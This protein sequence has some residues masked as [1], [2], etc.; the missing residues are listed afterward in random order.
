MSLEQQNEPFNIRDLTLD[1]RLQA[2]VE[3]TPRDFTGKKIFSVEFF[4]QNIGF[5]ITDVQ[6]EVNTSLQPIITITFKD[7]YGNT[8]FGKTK[9]ASA[10]LNDTVD[11]ETDFSVLFNWPPPKFLFTFKGFLGRSATW[12]INMKKSSV[13]YDS[14][15]GSYDIK[16]EFVPNQWGFL[17]DLPFLYLLAVKSLKKKSGMSEEEFKKVQTIFDLIKIGKQVEVKTQETTKEFDNIMKQMTLLK[18]QRF[19]D[20]VF[21]SKVVNYDE[22][23]T[24]QVGNQTIAPFNAV[25]VFEPKG[26]GNTSIDSQEKMKALAINSEN[27][28]RINTFLLFSSKIGTLEPEP[29]LTFEKI[30]TGNISDVITDFEQK[31][32]ARLKLLTDNITTIE[33]AIKKKTYDSSKSQ[34]EKI[35][36][37]EIFEQLAKD[38]GYIMGRILEI[39]YRGYQANRGSRDASKGQLIGRNFPLWLNDKQEEKPATRDVTGTDF[40]VEE[41][42]LQFVNDFIDAIAEG[43]A[44]ELAEDNLAAENAG[45]NL[46][47]KRISNIEALRPNPYKPFYQSIAENIM[48]RSGIAGFLTRSPDPNRPGDYDTTANRDRATAAEDIFPLADADFENISDSIITALSD[49]DFKA[50]KKFCVF[51]DNLLTEDCESLREPDGTG[52]LIEGNIISGN[53]T[54]APGSP[55]P[56]SL[57]DYRVVIER[58]ANWDG[59]FEAA[60]VQD[61]TLKE[62]MATV[63]RP[64][65]GNSLDSTNSGLIDLNALQAIKVINN[66][67]AYFKTPAAVGEDVYTYIMFDG[68]YA[69]QTQEVM[70][71]DS[72]GEA[73]NNIEEQ[74][75]S[76]EPVGFVN[77]KN[78]TDDEGNLVEV[79]QEMNNRI[80]D[81]LLL[82]Y[83]RLLNPN[84]SFFLYPNSLSPFQD[85]N[86]MDYFKVTKKLGDPDNLQVGEIPAKNLAFSIAYHSSDSAA[87]LV[88]GPFIDDDDAIVQRG[89]IKRI[90]S[91]LI[92]KLDGIEQKRNQ[93]ISDV[94]GKSGEQRDLLYKQMHVLYQQWEVLIIKDSDSAN[95]QNSVASDLGAAV[96]NPALGATPGAISQELTERY[97]KHINFNLAQSVAD[98]AYDNTFLYA[99]P[100]NSTPGFQQINV[101]N[102]LINIEPLYKPNG[103][104]TVLNIIQQICT[105]N[106]FIFIPMPGEP[107]VFST[108]EIFS[109]HP[110][111]K[112]KVKNFFYVQF[113]PTMESRA[114]LRNDDASPISSSQNVK[115]HLP[116]GTLLIKFGSPENQIV[117][118]IS[119][120]TQE[121]KSTA[122]SIVNLQ[123]LVDNENQNKKVTT[124]CSMLPVMEGRSYK[125]TAEM[126]GN[127]Q[128][129]PMQFF[130][131]DSIPL[132]NG[133]YQIMKVRHTIKPNDMTTSAEGIRMRMDFQTGEFGGIPPVTLETL[134]NLPV[135][136]VTGDSPTFSPAD[137]ANAVADQGVGVNDGKSGTMAAGSSEAVGPV[138][139]VKGGN[140]IKPTTTVTTSGVI[141]LPNIQGVR[142]SI[143]ITQSSDANGPVPIADFKAAN[144]EVFKK[145]DIIRDMNYFIQDVLEPFAGWLKTKYPKLYKNWYITSATRSYSPTGGAKVSQHQ[146]GQAIDS[147]II[148]G[149]NV[150][151]TMKL[152][153]QL[154]NAI[155][156]WYQSNPVGYDQMLWETRKPS[157][158]WIH[159]SYVRTRANRIQ[160]LRFK[161]DKT[162]QAAINKTGSYVLPGV[163]EQQVVLSL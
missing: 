129:F 7:L 133:L 150:T 52:K 111:D 44:T 3:G 158:S 75:D 118:N 1:V 121:S 5:G 73:K 18:S 113:A 95:G 125:A 50:L 135:T 94:L 33:N 74:K 48:I 96:V 58:P 120:D 51:W 147:Q 59:N 27:L 103:N 13:S 81:S 46:I 54:S 131:L 34:L 124:D 63:F 42:E 154:L 159:W 9:N 86:H 15:D 26:G 16:C 21:L 91:K 72:D 98:E 76:D 132:F 106:N 12:M 17:S 87:D 36:I 69:N 153:L 22:A 70:S 105:K 38:A 141:L 2:I 149:A 28:R 68:Q 40:G 30:A 11:A 32:N 152:N 89:Y 23:I 162:Y 148:G 71:A 102:S 82:D 25:T 35:T 140:D 62:I 161:D 114:T 61:T 88:F 43:I 80:D 78:P 67:L 29:G 45:S 116:T 92:E 79:V 156:E 115:D 112:P 139:T 130:Y 85:L 97:E 20:A 49:E 143:R 109:P 24:G 65:A 110:T 10:E 100:L 56:S 144:G 107:G 157:S 122:E 104:T 14:S 137:F 77:I 6:I 101:R 60:G 108:A 37:G 53:Y 142:N 145:E 160:L 99:Y 31:K 8:V 127:A 93:V 119:V 47:K 146:K 66:G 57:L 163:T 126:L 138:A 117:K 83:S 19:Y 64:K 155:L 128:V 41:Y 4:R 136:I 134:A 55:L 151:E 84:N 90:C 39:G 123:R